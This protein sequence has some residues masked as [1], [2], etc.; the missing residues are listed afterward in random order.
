MQS[1]ANGRRRTNRRSDDLEGEDDLKKVNNNRRRQMFKGSDSEEVK[2]ANPS[3][4]SKCEARRRCENVGPE[5][6]AL[7]MLVLKARDGVAVCSF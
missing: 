4:P 3:D 7:W 5:S 2:E 6:C 1:L